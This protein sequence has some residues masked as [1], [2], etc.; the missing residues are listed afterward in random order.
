MVKLAN[1]LWLVRNAA[2]DPSITTTNRTTSIYKPYYEKLLRRLML[3]YG[4]ILL[5][6]A[7]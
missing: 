6:P 5:V 3:E 2:C 4:D 1:V 7:H